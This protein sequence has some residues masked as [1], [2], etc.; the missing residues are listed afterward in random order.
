MNTQTFT[1]KNAEEEKQLVQTGLKNGY[2]VIC[3]YQKIFDKETRTVTWRV[4]A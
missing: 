1:P 3:D 4:K 2:K